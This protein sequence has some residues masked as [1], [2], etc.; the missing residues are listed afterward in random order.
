MCVSRGD[1]VAAFNIEKGYNFK[2]GDSVVDTQALIIELNGRDCS[3]SDSLCSGPLSETE[4]LLIALSSKSSGNSSLVPFS[5]KN[6]KTGSKYRPR[7]SPKKKKKKRKENQFM[8]LT[9]T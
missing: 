8:P 1:G 2:D 9:H 4:L 5:C 6:F 7:C 3:P